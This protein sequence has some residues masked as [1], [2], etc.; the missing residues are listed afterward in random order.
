MAGSF[1]GGVHPRDEKE[2][3]SKKSVRKM[4]EPS[5][6]I[7]PMLQHIGAP[8]KPLVKKGDKVK[9]GQVIGDS[10]AKV[11]APV[12]ASI[13][14]TVV[15]VGPYIAANGTEVEAV[16]I[17][18]DGTG[19]FDQSFEKYTILDEVEPGE[20]I[21]RIRA[22]GI[23][24]MGGAAFPTHF[25]LT[26]PKG[27]RFD[28]LIING[29]E[30]EPYLTADHRLMLEYPDDI[31]FGIRALL[32]ATGAE[33]CIIGI[34]LN[35]PDAIALMKEKCRDY[36][37]ISVEGLKV[38][39][40]QGAEK[41]LIKALTGREV[42]SGGLPVD[43]GAVVVNIGTTK[44]VADALRLGMPLIE[45]IVTVSGRGVKEPSNLK[46]KIG[47]PIAELI[48]ACGGY[49]GEP[50]KIIVGGPMMGI[51]QFTDEVV[52]TKGTSGVLVFTAD[53]AKAYEPGP[54]IRCG[55][56]VRNC[57]M[58]LIPERLTD[59]VEQGMYE[60]AEREGI[61][62]CIECGVC[63]YICPGRRNVVQTIRMG[64]A[65]VLAK[66]AKKGA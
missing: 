40:P 29:V 60:E 44:A 35:K 63:S 38:K 64:K 19:E 45:R 6:V 56:C 50:E 58:G 14:G 59:Y 37:K 41:Q 34:E 15:S 36:G 23:V 1:K 66:R 22:A 18:S 28:T 48:E 17:E 30:C 55:K 24:G 62:D 21:E 13:S 26:A 47:T 57:P 54:C 49:N 65:A 31:V 27:K 32:K 11:S 25:K 39:Y 61:M 46:V 33:R 10:E 52:V 9:A 43:V 8:C 20:I 53:E 5:K 42:P 7:I 51:A 2:L 3:T 4:N 16:T 12:H